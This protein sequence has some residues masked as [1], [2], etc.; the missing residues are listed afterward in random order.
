MKIAEIRALRPYN[1]IKHSKLGVCIVH[2]FIPDLGLVIQP[3]D[4]ANF[5]LERYKNRILYKL[6]RFSKWRIKNKEK[7]KTN[8]K[9]Y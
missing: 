8:K 6:S 9:A 3:V 5:I 1:Y 4:T 7:V 2:K